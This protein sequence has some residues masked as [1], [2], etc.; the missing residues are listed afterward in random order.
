MKFFAGKE[1]K[2]YFLHTVKQAQ[3]LDTLRYIC[4]SILLC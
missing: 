4:S 3:V 1:A 2:N